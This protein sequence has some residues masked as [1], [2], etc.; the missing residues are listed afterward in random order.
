MRAL[1]CRLCAHAVLWLLCCLSRE[2]EKYSQQAS[3]RHGGGGSWNVQPVTSFYLLLLCVAVAGAAVCIYLRRLRVVPRRVD[4]SRV[5]TMSY[6]MVDDKQQSDGLLVER[7]SNLPGSYYS[8]YA[9][10]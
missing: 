7:D 5:P 3:S 4:L 8:S 6:F 2:I 1:F 9:A 10:S